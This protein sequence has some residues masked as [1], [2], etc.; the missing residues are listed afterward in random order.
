MTGAPLGLLERCHA[1]KDKKAK[2]LPAD[3]GLFAY[4]VLMAADILAYD[5]DVV[6][7]GEDQ[8][9]HIEVC[10]D[11]AGFNHEYGETFVLPKAKVLDTA[12]RV[13]GIDG[14]K[15][16]KSYNN[17]LEVFEEPKSL[18]K[19]IMRIVTD[20][21][22]MDQPKEPDTDHL[23]QLYSLFATTPSGRRWP[24]SATAA[25]ATGKSRR[26]WPT[27]P[28]ASLPR[29]ASAA[30]NWRP[31][32]PA[33]ARSSPTAPPRP[34]RKRRRSSGVPS[35]LRDPAAGVRQSDTRPASDRPAA[36][37]FPTAGK[38]ARC[39]LPT[40]RPAGDAVEVRGN[41]IAYS[42]RR[43]QP[44]RR[45]VWATAT[46]MTALARKRRKTSTFGNRLSSDVPI[47]AEE[48]RQPVGSIDDP[49]QSPVY[50]Q[51]KAMGNSRRT[52]RIPVAS[53]NGIRGRQADGIERRTRHHPSARSSCHGT[54]PGVGKSAVQFLGNRRIVQG[55]RDD[56]RRT[57]SRSREITVSRSPSESCET[58]S[59]P[60]QVPRLA[61]ASS[62]SPFA[63][64][65]LRLR[66]LETMS[67]DGGL[68]EVEESFFK[69]AISAERAFS[70]PNSAIRPSSG[71]I[72]SPIIA[73][74]SS[75]V[76]SRSMP[77]S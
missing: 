69:R 52:L 4:P 29:P 72:A 49:L 66:R 51:A 48:D 6:P 67:L 34:A 54:L 47:V 50:R 25:S 23:F 36:V 37:S 71:A 63:A 68:E 22:P 30:G 17:T 27:W 26:P 8:T 74:T 7:V 12:A 5:S 2:G 75:S 24:R 44:G 45:L 62:F 31:T 76:N 13:P 16:S 28:R 59:K 20:S 9:Q 3:A 41:R 40:R 1:Y 42:R 53:A 10:R 64:G 14:E 35:G 58:A 73:R 21:R 57:I 56:V 11:L 19:Q 70:A 60:P 15:M 18:R 55:H 77:F 33:S 65:R 61:A 46:T 43:Q 38:P 39:R 32:Q